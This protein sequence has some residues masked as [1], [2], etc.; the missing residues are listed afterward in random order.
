MPFS[1]DEFKSAVSKGSGLAKP[2][3]FNIYLPPLDPSVSTKELNLLCRA[4]A[5][6]GKQMISQDVQMGLNTRKISNGFGVT[7]ITLTF[8]VLNDFHVKKYFEMWQDMVV[9]R[10]GEAY[11]IG[12]YNDYVKP[13]RIE[14]V[15]KKMSIP[16]FK[17]KLFNSTGVADTVLKRIARDVGP[18]GPFDLSQG[19]ID[20]SFGGENN[21]VYKVELIE[22]YPTSIS[23][24]VLTNDAGGL[25]E[26]TV[27]LSYKDFTSSFSK[28]DDSLGDI[29]AGALINKFKSL[30]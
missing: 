14:S 12:Y 3:L 18:I 30:F 25:M 8:Y 1:I 27:Q 28:I 23:E 16:V 22:A 19:E 17:K 15:Q 11:E 7:D 10:R 13:V 24:L 4:A 21:T 26:L 2:N 5:L 20:L 9:K 29:I 6:P